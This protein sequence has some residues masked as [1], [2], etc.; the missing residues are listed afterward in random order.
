[1][2]AFQMC[3]TKISILRYIYQF[4]HECIYFC[5]ARAYSTGVFQDAFSWW[6]SN[7]AVPD[8]HGLQVYKCS[9]ERT[10]EPNSYSEGELFWPRQTKMA[11][12]WV[13]LGKLWCVQP[14]TAICTT[15]SRES[16]PNSVQTTVASQMCSTKISTLRC[17]VFWR[18]ITYL[19]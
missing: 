3:S 7:I 6:S 5:R 16:T 11:H 9:I 8:A 15:P 1:M 10:V 12:I 2:V 19:N 18:N 4:C 17:F 14:G 13:R